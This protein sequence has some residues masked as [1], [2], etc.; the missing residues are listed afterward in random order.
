MASQQPR[1]PKPSSYYRVRLLQA[2][3][4]RQVS[5][6]EGLNRFLQ[7]NNLQFISR[8][9]AYVGQPPAG[10]SLLQELQRAGLIKVGY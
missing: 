6:W 10:I 5:G 2:I 9:S 3:R 8:G 4:D 1:S 7:D